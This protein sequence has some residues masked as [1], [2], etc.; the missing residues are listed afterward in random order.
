MNDVDKEKRDIQHDGK[1]VVYGMGD[2]WYMKQ[3]DKGQ[4]PRFD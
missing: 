3:L 4:F 1:M 2:P